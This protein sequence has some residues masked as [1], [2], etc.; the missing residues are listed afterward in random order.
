MSTEW[1]RYTRGNPCPICGKDRC[2]VDPD[3][4][5]VLC[6][7][8]SDGAFQPAEEGFL[9]R[10]KERD[11]S[12]PR[13]AISP[14]A[15]KPEDIVPDFD[16]EKFAT[17]CF[18]HAMQY[19]VDELMLDLGLHRDV[20]NPFM[21]GTARLC[22][23][24]RGSDEFC[25][26]CDG[27]RY[28]PGWAP[29]EPFVFTF[30]MR[31]HLGKVIGIRTRCPMT[32]KKMAIKGSRAGLFYFEVSGNLI[33]GDE[34][35]YLCEGPTDAASMFWI[36]LPV[37]GRP[38]ASGGAVLLRAWFERTGRPAVIVADNDP[39]DKHGRRP[40]LEGARRLASKLIGAAK[41]V[42]IITPRDGKDARAWI[43]SMA[44]EIS[45]KREVIE[46]IVAAQ[47]PWT[48]GDGSLRS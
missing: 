20:S 22:A 23:C 25:F 24:C 32:A 30:P 11:P 6:W 16:A 45:G 36:G 2:M 33:A 26:E 29:D 18:D 31:N 12:L 9:H 8:V 27:R 10:I 44:P 19:K 15:P 38:S 28:T 7:R 13:R 4:E 37:I 42:R 47:R 35:V 3:R 21:V 41:W 40:G 5:V 48:D 17:E 1:T 34:P 14:P 46:A 43:N 39:K